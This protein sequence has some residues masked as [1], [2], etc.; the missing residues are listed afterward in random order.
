MLVHAELGD[1]RGWVGVVVKENIRQWTAYQI[2]TVNLCAL[3]VPIN[4]NSILM[5]ARPTYNRMDG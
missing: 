3:K 1:G 2:G 4:V 5:Y